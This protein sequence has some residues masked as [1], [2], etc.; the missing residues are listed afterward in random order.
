MRHYLLLVSGCILACTVSS[1]EQNT[2]LEK[3][4]TVT[5]K[6]S[7]SISPSPIALKWLDGTAPASDSGISWGVPWPRGQVAQEAS[8]T[9]SDSAGQSLPVQSWPLAF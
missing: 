3:A 2:P 6:K 8:F 1:A 7:N 9:L 4:T 5:F